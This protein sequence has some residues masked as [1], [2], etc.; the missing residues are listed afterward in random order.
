LL[1]DTF[2]IPRFFD[3]HVH[4]RGG[5][6]LSLVAPTTAR[7]CSRAVVMPNVPE[8][9][10]G[11][12]AVT[13]RKDILGEA[14]GARLVPYPFEPLMTIKLNHQTTP[15][16]IREAHGLGVVAGKV[17]PEGVTTGSRNGVR[18][19]ED[20][21]PCLAEME[22]SGMILCIHGEAP[23]AFVLDRETAYLRTVRVVLNVFPC[24]RVVLEHVTT[25]D[26]VRLVTD[27]PE[28]LAATITAHHLCLTLDDVIGDGIRP[29]HFCYP[30]AKRPS[31]RA[32][33]REAAMGLRGTRF[34]LG[35]DSAPH[36][37]EDKESACGCAGVYTA[38]V[39]P[40][41]LAGVFED[42]GADKEDLEDFTSRRG[43]AFYGLEPLPGVLTFRR[44]PWTVPPIWGTEGG[45]YTCGVVPFRAGETLT[46]RAE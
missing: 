38:P 24:L 20:L 17:Y 40:A 35:S 41:V 10:T 19:I 16:M 28:T 25:E 27:G 26:A 3:A 15:Q 7:Y 12:D 13:Y 8:V 4:L 21:A 2:K 23:G 42:M 33:L 18:Y 34:F 45:G 32:S 14:R 46:W 6:L 5:D 44:E 43:E 30:V 29:H 31:D 22:K 36:R 39:L 11:A 37:V 9:L 1:N